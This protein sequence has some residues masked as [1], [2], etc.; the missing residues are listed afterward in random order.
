MVVG[1]KNGCRNKTFDCG[2]KIIGCGQ[3]K[4]IV[5]QIKKAN[6]LICISEIKLHSKRQK[7]APLRLLKKTKL[8]YCKQS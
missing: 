8:R 4:S 7:G 2:N 5:I 1:T 3:K 6:E